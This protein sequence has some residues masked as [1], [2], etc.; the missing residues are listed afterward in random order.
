MRI[1]LVDNSLESGRIIVESLAP[2]HQIQQMMSSEECFRKMVAFS[3]DIVIVNDLLEDMPVLDFCQRIK[4]SPLGD[5][6][7]ILVISSQ[8]NVES[9]I[10][11]YD[12]GADDYIIQ[13]IHH[14]E[15][16]AKIQALGR[17]RNQLEK[18]WLAHFYANQQYDRMKELVQKKSEEIEAT[19]N[20][21]VFVIAKL[22][23]SRATGQGQ[24]LERIRDYSQILGEELYRRGTFPE[25]ERNFLVDLYNASP[26]H[27]LGKV[28]IPDH[29]LLKEGP[30]TAEEFNIMKQH[31]VIGAETLQ[32][33]MQQSG[34]SSFLAMS[35]D[36]ARH[37]HERFDGQ[38]YPDGLAGLDIPLAAQ[39]VSV[40]DVF[41][42]LTSQRVYKKAIAPDA[43]KIMIEQDTGRRFN[44]AIVRAFT[45]RFNDF[46]DIYVSHR[47]APA[48][49]VL[50]EEL[51][52]EWW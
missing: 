40:V 6:A 4:G 1:I 20:M 45:K 12:A 42:A 37:H 23:E 13:P 5:F 2:E 17:N 9:R 19:R 34:Y 44:P 25:I 30:L 18:L 47:D 35:I 11:Y 21:T 39:I 14:N 29:I 28:A 15:L 49:P 48:E 3:P 32:L 50:T 33:A 10:Q 8:K 43:V 31:S 24:H 26:L 27:D 16:R 41:D 38:G 22:A 46:M 52:T 7:T 51:A 36:I